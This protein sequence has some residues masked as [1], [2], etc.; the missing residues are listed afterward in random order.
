MLPLFPYAL[1]EGQTLLCRA[2]LMPATRQALRELYSKDQIL[3]FKV[4]SISPRKARVYVVTPCW[5]T[6]PLSNSRDRVA[7]WIDLRRTA[8]GWRFNGNWDAVWSECGSASG[9]VFPP[10][11]GKGEL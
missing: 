3:W 7:Q 9:N 5:D 1:V 2:A 11:L 4:L 8:Q 10:Y 6:P